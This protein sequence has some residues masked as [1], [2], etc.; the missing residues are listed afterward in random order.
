VTVGHA[1]WPDQ[2]S[3]SERGALD[4]GIPTDLRRAPDILIV[5]GG[6]LGVAIA[7]A[8]ATARLGSIVLLERDTLASGASGGAAGQLMPEAHVGVDPPELVDLG[9]TSLATW[10]HLEDTT[11]GGVGLIDL[12]WLG[13]GPAA[14]R[15]SGPLPPKTVQLNVDDVSALIPGLRHPRAGVLVRGQARLNPL[16][17]IARLVSALPRAMAQVATH[18]EVRAVSTYGGRITAVHSTAGNLTPGV[19]IFATGTP[20]RVDGLELDLPASEVKGHIVVTEPTTARLPGAVDPLATSLD[21]GRLLIGGSLDIGDDTRIVRAEILEAQW[22]ELVAAWPAAAGARIAYGWA[23]F[24]PAHHDRLPVIDRV[25]GLTNAWLTSGHY[26]T[27]ILMAP[28]TAD[29]LARWIQSGVV[30]DEVQFFSSGRLVAAS[31]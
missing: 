19:V 9:R 23:C 10:R 25:L 15:F 1:L 26:K 31:P 21:D 17:A 6:M 29:A 27:G 12:D 18:A 16:R 5:G 11:P 7:G 24:R 28:G 8:C 30:P 3:A 14:D 20:P 13:L 22:A 4:P 2:L